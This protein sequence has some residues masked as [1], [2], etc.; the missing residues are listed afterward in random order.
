MKTR[1]TL[2]AGC[3]ILAT[4]TTSGQAFAHGSA[5]HGTMKMDARMMKLHA[6][7]PVFSLASAQLETA[8]EKGDAPAA[9]TE[10]GKIL[11]SIPDLKLAK[12]HKNLKQRKQF[13]ALAVNLGQSV[14]AA[15]D[16]AKQGD[17]AAAK[18]AFQK[19]EE[20]CA[21]CHAKFR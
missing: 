12:P 6:M 1:R 20:T 11:A 17:F 21:A 16:L 4:V 15:N 7:M 18:V 9:A 14:T 8:L 19:V 5:E 2:A 10:A 13:V 3:L